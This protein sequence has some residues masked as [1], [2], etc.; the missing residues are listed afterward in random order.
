[1][2]RK[3]MVTVKVWGKYA[4]FTR[5]EFKVERVSY[6]VITP[7]AARGVLEAIFWKPEFRYE[8]RAIGVLKKGSEMVIL[9]NEIEQRQGSNPFFIEDT[10]QQRCSLVLKNV[11]YLIRAEIVLRSWA[12]D[13]VYKYRDQFNR[14]VERGQCY[15]RPYLGTREFT[16]FF[17]PAGEGDWPQPLDMDLGN[18]LL[19]IAY[20]EDPTRPE[21]EFVRHGPGGARRASGYH[22]ALFFAARLEAGWL[23]VPAERYRELYLLEGEDYV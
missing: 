21:M 9:R 12:T 20:V 16:A 18:M 8:I 22:H 11:A 23:R 17:A 15:H 3:G 13:P 6:P 4:C 14:R 1:M 19:D 7:S 5:P 2:E 10:R